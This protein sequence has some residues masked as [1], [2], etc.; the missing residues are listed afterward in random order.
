MLAK[1]TVYVYSPGKNSPYNVWMLI[2]LLLSCDR[3]HV[4]ASSLS[5][6]VIGLGKRLLPP[7]T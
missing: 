2:S 6:P 1:T 3:W 5:K 4:S 7:L